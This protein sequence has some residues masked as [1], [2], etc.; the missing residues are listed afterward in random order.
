M[1]RLSRRTSPLRFVALLSAVAALATASSSAHAADRIYWTNGSG[2][3]ISFVN[4]DTSSGGDLTTPGA[5]VDVPFGLSLDPAAGRIYWANNG[6]DT[7]AFANLDGSGD[8]GTVNTTGASINNPGGVAVDAANGRIYWASYSASKISFANLNDSGG[9]DLN[10]TGAT[11]T[12]PQG[13]TLDPAAGRIYWAS[14]FTDKISFANLNGT[15]GGDLTTT[16]ATVSDPEGVAVDR[17]AGR[18]YW[19]NG[20]ANKISF[21]NLNGSG[22]ADLN[23]TGA[24]VNQPTGVALDK[25]AG[26]VYW[27]NRGGNKVSYANLNGTGGGDVPTLSA[28]VNGPSFPVLLNAPQ[29]EAAPQ[30]T[31]GST[32]GSE[33][34]CSQ[35]SWGADL[36]PA[37][38]YRAPQSFA[39]SWSRD[40]Q[41]IAGASTPTHT[42]AVAG[43]Y[44]CTVSATNEAGTGAQTSAARV[45]KAD[46]VTPGFGTST[47]VTLKL[48]SN[49][50]GAAGPLPIA[51][52]NGNDFTVTGTLSG[53]TTKKVPGPKPR[54]IKLKAKSFTLDGKATRTIKLKLPA[55]LRQVL[56]RKK[57]LSL[58]LSAT[59]EDPAGQSRTVKKTVKPKLKIRRK[60]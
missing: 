32:P 44:R 60:R 50:I 18:I 40:G 1:Y 14:V 37:Q 46:V 31:G 25:A 54:R 13:V 8:G 53:R 51:I 20:A 16:G 41:A 29:G 15:G 28:S 22:G 33:L 36:L 57:K 58:A 47:L 24:T 21:A 30:V 10:T 34:S 27:A 6:P 55:P 38:L 5:T 52:A 49:K 59:V 4:L 3:T 39:Y 12:Q 35:G 11:A 56:R 17:A 48:K 7:I 2:N 9:S 42:A 26:R 23:T 43:E 45:V 19:A